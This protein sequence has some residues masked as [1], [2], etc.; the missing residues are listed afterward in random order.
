MKCPNHPLK[1]REVFAAR[2]KTLKKLFCTCCSSPLGKI[3][4]VRTRRCAKDSLPVLAEEVRPG[5]TV[6]K[7]CENSRRCSCGTLESW[8]GSCSN[9]HAHKWPFLSGPAEAHHVEKGSYGLKNQLQSDSYPQG[10]YLDEIV[11]NI[12]RCPIWCSKNTWS[13]LNVLARY[14]ALFSND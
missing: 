1:F 14:K 13:T 12:N 10:T 6:A 3:F 2:S 9:F 4:P 11:T 5:I 8:S 7:N